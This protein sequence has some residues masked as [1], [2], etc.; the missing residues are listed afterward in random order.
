MNTLISSV[1]TAAIIAS[2]VVVIV[3][4]VAVTW[5]IGVK[6]AEPFGVILFNMI[7]SLGTALDDQEASYDQEIEKSSKKSQQESRKKSE[8]LLSGLIAIFLCCFCVSFEQ[9]LANSAS[10]SV[11]LWWYL[12]MPVLKGVFEAFITLGMLRLALAAVRKL[13]AN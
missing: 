2:S 8:K 6:L 13:V 1:R 10:Y 4:F 11:G 7:A 9:A 5:I 12:C 3:A